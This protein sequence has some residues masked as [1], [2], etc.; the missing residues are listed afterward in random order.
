[1][2]RVMLFNR[3]DA[4]SKTK[5][6]YDVYITAI[7]LALTPTRCGMASFSNCPSYSISTLF[8]LILDSLL[9]LFCLSVLFPFKR[10][11]A[12][13]SFGRVER[14]YNRMR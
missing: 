13:Y 4:S 6:C 5:L 11:T 14:D 10:V 1:M 9:C 2:E 8:T 12:G 7:P 3:G